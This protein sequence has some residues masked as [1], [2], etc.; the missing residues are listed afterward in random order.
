MEKEAQ[1]PQIDYPRISG[2]DKEVLMELRRETRRAIRELE[3]GSGVPNQGHLTTPKV[4]LTEEIYTPSR[5]MKKVKNI[6]TL[7]D[8]VRDK[9]FLER[10]RNASEF[11]YISSK[12]IPLELINALKSL[13]LSDDNVH[14][15]INRENGTLKP[16]SKSQYDRLS[17]DERGVLRRPVLE[18]IR[19][20][21]LLHIDFSVVGWWVSCQAYQLVDIGL[22]PVAFVESTY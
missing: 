5:A 22:R 13:G 16:V 2:T 4:S 12:D 1:K 19:I 6:A 21:E 17:P 7:M 14:V 15:R 18:G 9:D 20:G 11:F 3:R 8:V 10:C